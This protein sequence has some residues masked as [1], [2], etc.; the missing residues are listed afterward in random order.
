VANKS[1]SFATDN[2]WTT[3]GDS[4]ASQPSGPSGKILLQPK[5]INQM[6]YFFEFQIPG[7]QNS[8]MFYG[9]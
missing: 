4:A 2:C 5:D 8:L 1:L 6:F 9:R 7:Y 3:G